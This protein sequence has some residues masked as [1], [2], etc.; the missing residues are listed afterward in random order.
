MESPG[1]GRQSIAMTAPLKVE[2][3]WQ[4]VRTQVGDLVVG[5]YCR[6]DI[7]KASRTYIYDYHITRRCVGARAAR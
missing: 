5:L 6:E 7:A 4:R 2:P 1:P 3:D